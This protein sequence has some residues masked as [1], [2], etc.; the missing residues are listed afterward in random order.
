VRGLI[1]EIGVDWNWEAA[2]NSDDRSSVIAEWRLSLKSGRLTEGEIRA[3]RADGNFAGVLPQR[4]A[5]G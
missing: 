5:A 4:G 2:T 3:Q 1:A